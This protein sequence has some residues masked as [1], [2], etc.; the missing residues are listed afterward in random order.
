MSKNKI[1]VWSYLEDHQTQ[2]KDISKLVNEV[3]LSGRLISRK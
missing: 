2:K 1:N 3:F